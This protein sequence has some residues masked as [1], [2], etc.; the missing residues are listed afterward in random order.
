MGREK[1]RD[2]KV[3]DR[4]RVMWVFLKGKVCL[5]DKKQLAIGKGVLTGEHLL[6]GGSFCL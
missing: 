1:E 6:P 3:R 4:G 2:R 5:G